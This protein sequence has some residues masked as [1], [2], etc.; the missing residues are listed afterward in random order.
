MSLLDRLR[1]LFTGWSP[2]AEPL[3]PRH[4]RREAGRER[5]H[6][7]GEPPWTSDDRVAGEGHREVQDVTPG[8]P[9]AGSSHRVVGD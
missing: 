8:T 9:G 3:P 7:S 5:H 2:P 1:R 6:E 4:E